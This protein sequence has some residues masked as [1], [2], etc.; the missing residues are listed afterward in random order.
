MSLSSTTSSQQSNVSS[1]ELVSYQDS[2]ES[3]LAW[4]LEAEES[5]KQQGDIADNVQIV[6]DQFHHHEVSGHGE[7]REELACSDYRLW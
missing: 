6:K 3:V 1:L 4:L 5:L 7:Q 2:L